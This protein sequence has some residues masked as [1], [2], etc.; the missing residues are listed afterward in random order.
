MSGVLTIYVNGVSA[1]SFS[2]NRIFPGQ[3]LN[4]VRN[5]KVTVSN[6]DTITVGLAAAI[7]GDGSTGGWSADVTVSNDSSGNAVLD[8]FNAGAAMDS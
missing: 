3:T 8:T 2:W 4:I 5:A 7:T 6:N 1:N